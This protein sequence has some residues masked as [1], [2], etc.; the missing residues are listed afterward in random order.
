M[1]KTH[2]DPKLL[3]R[4][5]VSE[6]PMHRTTYASGVNGIESSPHIQDVTCQVCIRRLLTHNWLPRLTA[7]EFNYLIATRRARR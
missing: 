3:G 1:A 5:L 6:T 4:T 2:F 7:T